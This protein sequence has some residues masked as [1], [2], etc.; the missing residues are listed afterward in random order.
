MLL[1]FLLSFV[2]LLFV[3]VVLV[4]WLV[5][6][7]GEGGKEGGHLAKGVA[8]LAFVEGTRGFDMQLWHLAG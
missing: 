8:I 7:V 4:V 1:L 2:L 6:F 3:V 5:V